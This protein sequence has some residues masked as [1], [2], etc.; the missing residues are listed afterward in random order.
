VLN[1]EIDILWEQDV[2]FRLHFVLADKLDIFLYHEIL[3]VKA[4]RRV[5]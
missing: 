3:F 1:F 4:R 5:L 2:P